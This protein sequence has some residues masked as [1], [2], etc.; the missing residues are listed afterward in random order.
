M[1]KLAQGLTDLHSKR[2]EVDLAELANLPPR[3]A[4]THNCARAFL[5]RIPQPKLP[6][7]RRTPALRSATPVALAARQTA[8]HVIAG[9]DIAVEVVCSTASKIWSA[10]RRSRN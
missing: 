6:R 1:T 2:G 4:A 5:A 7:W 9:R 8:E 3:Q 10:G